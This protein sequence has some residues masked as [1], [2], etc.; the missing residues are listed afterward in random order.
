M[1]WEQFIARRPSA[2]Q[3]TQ[4]EHPRL[5]NLFNSNRSSVSNKSYKSS[6]FVQYQGTFITK[7]TALHL[8]QENPILSRNRQTQYGSNCCRFR[9]FMCIQACTWWQKLLLG[10]IIKFSLALRGNKSTQ[11]CM[12][13]LKRINPELEH[14][15]TGFISRH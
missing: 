1:H 15:P 14:L 11:E 7:S 9:W 4:R 10:R 2:N 12:Y 13:T 5:A 6:Q 8:L 3:V